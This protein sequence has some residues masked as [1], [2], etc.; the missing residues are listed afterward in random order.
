MPDYQLGKI[1]VIHNSEN[2]NKYYSSTTLA[3]RQRL[4]NHRSACRNQKKK[5]KFYTA[6]REIGIEKF[7]I[8][9]VEE[10]PCNSKQDLEKTEAEFIQNNREFSYNMRVPKIINFQ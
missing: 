6:M 5:S 9:L 4:Y 3:L 2:E 1:Y 8:E 7:R 10:R